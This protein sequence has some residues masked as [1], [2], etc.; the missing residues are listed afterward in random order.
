MKRNISIALVI[1]AIIIGFSSPA[2]S[3]EAPR[4]GLIFN[5]SNILM[6]IESYQ[7]GIGVKLRSGNSAFRFLADGF[8]T[9]SSMTMS[10]DFGVAYEYHLASARV[11]PY[12]GGFAAVGYTSQKT[13]VDAD[14]W[15][16]NTSTPISAGV[17][18][19]AEVFV[20]DFLSLF[21]EYQVAADITQTNVKISTDGTVADDPQN[22]FVFDTGIGNGSKIGIVIYLK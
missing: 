6:D 5:A 1:I 10:V 18:L 2:W 20:T 8:F 13:T 15:T 4:L 17:L 7:A 3:Q 22:S 14:N 19:G 12:V 9:N 21:A 11:S 16:Q